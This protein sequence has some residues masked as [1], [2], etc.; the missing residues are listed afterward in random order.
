M[1]ELS[2]ETRIL[3]LIDRFMHH[4]TFKEIAATHR[5]V[6]ADSAK[7][8][9]R[10][11]SQR[12]STNNIKELLKY[13]DPLPKPGRPATVKTGSATGLSIRHSVA[14][15]DP[16]LSQQD[17]ANKAWKRARK[18]DV[19]PQRRALGELAP[20]Q[21][22]NICQ[23]EKH[24]ECDNYKKKPIRRLRALRK[25]AL[26][27]LDLLHRKRY[28]EQIL[29]MDPRTTVIILCDETPMQFG[30]SGGRQHA[31]A[32][33]GDIVYQDQEDPRF[34]RM[35][36]D[37]CSSDIRA[38]RRIAIWTPEDDELKADLARKLQEAQVTLDAVVMGQRERA[39][40]PGT[41]EHALLCEK[42][43]EVKRNNLQ[44]P[45]G[46]R[47][48][49]KH[50]FTPERLFPKEVISRDHRKGGLDA[51]FYAFE[52]YQKLLFP[53]Y[54]EVQALNPTKKV[55]IIEDNVGVHHKAR[56][57]LRP[58]INEHNIEFLDTPANSP[59]L[60]PIEHLHKDQKRLLSEYRLSITS[61]AKD[62]QHQ[63]E[64]R[65]KRI[66][67][68]DDEFDAYVRRRCRMG[69]L[70]GLCNKAKHCKP[71]YSNRYRDSL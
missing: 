14:F 43:E 12:A 62:I 7:T 71:R 17:A 49:I 69:Y 58:Y 53:Y 67:V 27:K 56:R 68:E 55:Y 33:A 47:K 51:I 20:A 40:Q 31:S 54:L 19:P 36:W 25:P 9:C 15:R 63:A 45:R 18:N 35:Q 38:K 39:G 30:G 44:I 29:A 3:I 50:K 22:H 2:R 48:G 57:I 4:K 64:E 52:I 60:N 59:D 32:Y 61:A 28:C 11:I 42:N 1:R 5:G 46:V 13:I 66:W 34:S 16:Y 41:P 24:N 21:V 6:N 65:M 10:R 23:G 8:L 26:R 70:K 37:S